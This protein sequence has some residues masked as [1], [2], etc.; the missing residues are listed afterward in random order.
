MIIADRESIQTG[1][2]LRVRPMSLVVRLRNVGLPGPE[3][4]EILRTDDPRLIHR[5]LELHRERLE[6]RL[7]EQRAVLGGI[8]ALLTGGGCGVR[9]S[10]HA[11]AG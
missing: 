5:Y 10:R 6:E 1:S 3:I 8:E 11:S 9:G 4:D 7:A 2:S